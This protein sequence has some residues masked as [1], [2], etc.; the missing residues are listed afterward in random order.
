MKNRTIAGF[1]VTKCSAFQFLKKRVR[2]WKKSDRFKPEKMLVIKADDPESKSGKGPRM[3]A[4][5]SK[6]ECHCCQG[7]IAHK[8]DGLWERGSSKCSPKGFQE[9]GAACRQLV[10]E[11]CGPMSDSTSPIEA[12]IGHLLKRRERLKRWLPT[13]LSL[14]RTIC[15]SIWEEG[16]GGL[17]IVLLFF[18]GFMT[19]CRRR[20]SELQRSNVKVNSENIPLT[21][22]TQATAIQ[23]Q[24]IL[25]IQTSLKVQSRAD[26]MLHC[27]LRSAPGRPS[28]SEEACGGSQELAGDASSALELSGPLQAVS[29]S[30]FHAITSVPEV[31]EQDR[32]QAPPELLVADW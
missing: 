28:S 4:H 7:N 30:P 15:G 20:I 29:T 8:C 10:Q 26:K 32:A 21:K 9:A 24:F 18:L 14:G 31:P 13:F 2:K 25:S 11:G 23:V 19:I 5:S 22:P 12:S 6:M 3:V 17:M 16:F 27:E 1:S